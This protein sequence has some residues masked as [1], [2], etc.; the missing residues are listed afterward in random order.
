MAKK[1]IDADLLRKEIESRMGDCDANSKNP[2]Q[3]LWAELAALIPFIDSL[4]QEQSCEDLKKAAEVRAG[5]WDNVEV[6]RKS[7]SRK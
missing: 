6:Y 5:R 3:L 1:Y 4:Q 7:V 2:N